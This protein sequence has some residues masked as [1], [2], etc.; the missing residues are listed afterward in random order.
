MNLDVASPKSL[1]LRFNHRYMIPNL[2]FYSLNDIS[3]GVLNGRGIEGVILD[4]DNV[5]WAHGGIYPNAEVRQR[6]GKLAE[7]YKGNICLLTNMRDRER[8]EKVELNMREVYGIPIV[9]TPYKKPDIRAYKAA[10]DTIGVEAHEV[11]M[12]DDRIGSLTGARKLGITTIL[13][14]PLSPRS[15]P[16]V[17]RVARTIESGWMALSNFLFNP[18]S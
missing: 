16:E 11:V 4:G 1:F 18:P 15:E 9:D 3:Q 5:L 17:F 6:V 14:D 13:V 7:K 2:R 8:R 12:I 10:L